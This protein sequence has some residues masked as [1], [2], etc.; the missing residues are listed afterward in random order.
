VE[1]GTAFEVLDKSG[2]FTCNDSGTVVDGKTVIT[3][4]GKELNSFDLKLT[5]GACGGAKLE[6]G[7]G[8]CQEGFGLDS[9][10]QC[11]APLGGDA[12]GSVVVTVDL[13]PCP[14]PH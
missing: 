7:T 14:L 6:K 10:Q 5:N 1:P 8:R 2:D 11:C 12:S 9:A 13:G 4:F 3:C